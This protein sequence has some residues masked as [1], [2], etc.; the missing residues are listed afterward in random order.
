MA[1]YMQLADGADGSEQLMFFQLPLLLPAPNRSVKSEPGKG[2]K[3]AAADDDDEP[4]P[5][6]LP[7]QS[8]PGGLVRLTIIT[9]RDGTLCSGCPTHSRVQSTLNCTAMLC[10]VGDML[11][12]CCCALPHAVLCGCRWAS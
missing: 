7:I 9:V 3:A 12:G 2:L 5:K 6:S 1:E 10:W 11:I 4:P 8:A